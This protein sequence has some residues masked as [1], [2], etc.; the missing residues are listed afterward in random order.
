MTEDL[1]FEEI[2]QAL[3]ANNLPEAQRL[4]E[5]AQRNYG[6]SARLLYLQG[7]LHMKQ[8]EWGEAIGCFLKA[9][10]LEPDGPARQC[11][12]MLQEIL[13]FYNKDMYNQ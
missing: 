2:D 3:A 5:L 1:K 6:T 9:E 10:K 4:A 8:S 12:M 13:E 7:K 11:R